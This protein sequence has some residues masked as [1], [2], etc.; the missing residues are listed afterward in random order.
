MT[1]R[2]FTA[3]QIETFKNTLR[4]QLPP[5][6][7]VYTSVLHVSRSGMSRE[8]AAYLHTPD[9]IQDISWMVAPVIGSR[10]GNTG[11]VV[12]G[13]AGM[14]MT[15]ALVYSLS[16]ALYPEGHKCTG[17]TGLTPQGKPSK[18]PRCTSNDH[19]NDYGMLARKYDAAHPDEDRA[20]FAEGLT[21]EESHRLRSEYVSARQAW[22]AAQKTYAKSRN[23]SDGGYSLTRISL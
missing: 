13:G 20:E 11:G 6:S 17:S 10:M 8:I 21:P 4:A 16:R 14:D 7:R 22:I 3:D 9:S 12:M 23:H 5:G 2:R 15:H 19:S 1:T 18:T